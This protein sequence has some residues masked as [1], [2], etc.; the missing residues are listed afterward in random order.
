MGRLKVLV[1]SVSV[2]HAVAGLEVAS[3]FSFLDRSEFLQKLCELSSPT[4]RP[5]DTLNRL[6]DLDMVSIDVPIELTSLGSLTYQLAKEHPSLVPELLHAC[7][8]LRHLS[9]G[10]RE[11]FLT[12]KLTTDYYYRQ[13]DASVVE[14]AG[15]VLSGLLDA[16]GLDPG[17]FGFDKSSVSKSLPYLRTLTNGTKIPRDAVRLEVVVYALRV[18]ANYSGLSRGQ[19]IV[20]NDENCSILSRALY[21][22]EPRLK[23]LVEQATTASSQLYSRPTPFGIGVGLT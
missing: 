12:Y 6:R 15:V 14:T 17:S 3:R 4:T 9:P 21:V 23:N 22:E 16:L 20:L 13:P 10:A 18:F 5:G 8:Y 11:Y 7:H 1:D 2:W 19:L